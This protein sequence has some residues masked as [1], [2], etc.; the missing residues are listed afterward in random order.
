MPPFAS[1]VLG[2]SASFVAPPPRHGRAGPGHPR[3][4]ERH[5]PRRQVRDDG[6]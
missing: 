5:G 4:T 6:L 3:E 2:E 1:A